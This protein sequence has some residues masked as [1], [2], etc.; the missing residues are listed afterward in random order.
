MAGE[1][2]PVNYSTTDYK[3]ENLNETKQ[4]KQIPMR[5]VLWEQSSGPSQAVSMSMPIITGTVRTQ[6]IS[7]EKGGRTQIT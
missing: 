3:K 4:N 2:A 5:N 6:E 7:T 1:V